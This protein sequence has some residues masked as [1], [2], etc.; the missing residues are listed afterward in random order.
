MPLDKLLE[1]LRVMM[2]RRNWNQKR[3]AQEAGLSPLTVSRIISGDTKNPGVETLQK[4][5]D[6]MGYTLKDLL[7]EGKSHPS[8]ATTEDQ[9]RKPEKEARTASPNRTSASRK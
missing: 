6:A 1:N 4:L 5:V 3:L 7:D 9:S 2:A 8:L